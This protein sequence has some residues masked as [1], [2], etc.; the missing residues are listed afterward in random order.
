MSD[1]LSNCAPLPTA[2]RASG[3]LLHV[4]SLPSAYGIGD[5]GPGRSRGLTVY[6]MPGKLGGSRC[7]SVRLATGTR[8]INRCLRSRVTI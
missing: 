2:Y 3:L 5:L 7:H 1:E 8:R 6:M 4:T